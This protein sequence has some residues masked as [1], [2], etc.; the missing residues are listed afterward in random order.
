M[1]TVITFT[2]MQ[3]IGY[4]SAICGV[5]ISAGAVVT[6][7][8]KLINKVRAPEAEQDRRIKELEED[9]K[10]IRDEI[11]EIKNKQDTGDDQFRELEKSN[12]I[13][14]R[15]LQALLRHSLGTDNPEALTDAMKELDNY[16]VEK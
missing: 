12:K 9:N 15:S 3:L 16:L 11:K 10:K 7:I 13:I 1:D 8:I 5:I 2:P 6:L 4:I 14:L